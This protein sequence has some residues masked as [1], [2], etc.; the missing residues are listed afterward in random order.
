MDGWSW[1][2][3]SVAAFLAVT[4]L[5]RFML[6]RRNAL[7]EELH[8]KAEAQKRASAQQKKAASRMEQRSDNAA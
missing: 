7:V 4:V 8:R 6:A 1:V 5:V 3:L 2:L